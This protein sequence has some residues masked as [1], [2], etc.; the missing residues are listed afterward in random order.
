MRSAKDRLPL[1]DRLWANVAKG[2]ADACWPWRAA[3]RRGGYGVI[4]E[5]YRQMSAHRVAYE[6]SVGPIGDGLFVC[7]RCDNPACCNPAHL[8]LGTAQQNVADMHAKG[9][10][11]NP[12]KSAAE[13]ANAAER[14]AEELEE[15]RKGRK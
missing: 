2:S 3:T 9:R 8:F 5:N 15:I 1:S 11:G 7:H 13:L 12:A 4:R 6:L 10:A 14:I